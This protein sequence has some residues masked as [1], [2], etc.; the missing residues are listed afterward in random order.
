MLS[1]YGKK[2]KSEMPIIIKRRWSISVETTPFSVINPQ[3]VFV[4]DKEESLADALQCLGAILDSE[5]DTVRRISEL[6]I[7]VQ[8]AESTNV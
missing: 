1:G 4:N 8:V 5:P 6:R 3:R 7:T 2:E